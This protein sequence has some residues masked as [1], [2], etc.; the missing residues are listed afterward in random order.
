MDGRGG[1]LTS[2]LYLEA[3]ASPPCG[4]LVLCYETNVVFSQNNSNN[5]FTTK[6]Q[7][8]RFNNNHQGSVAQSVA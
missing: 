6:N 4:H 7:S 3:Q 1:L 5:T 2:L 8:S